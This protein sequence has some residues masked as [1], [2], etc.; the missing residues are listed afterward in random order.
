LYPHDYGQTVNA[1]TIQLLRSS[2]LPPCSLSSN[3]VQNQRGSFC[4]WKQQQ[5]PAESKESSIGLVSRWRKAAC[6]LSPHWV[7]F[8]SDRKEL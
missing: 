4:I 3:T 1:T 6:R 7:K 2:P 5:Y 8:Y